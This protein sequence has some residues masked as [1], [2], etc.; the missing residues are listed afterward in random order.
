MSKQICAHYQIVGLNLQ[1][2]IYKRSDC[3]IYNSIIFLELR[4]GKFHSLNIDYL[5]GTQVNVSPIS[6]CK[7]K[8]DIFTR[9]KHVHDITI[10]KTLPFTFY[11]YH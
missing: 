6:C 5:L 4:E 2:I 1:T 8:I 9:S 7:T 10:I 11:H 3:V